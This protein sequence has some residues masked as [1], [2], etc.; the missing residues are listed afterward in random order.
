MKNFKVLHVIATL[1]E[2]LGGPVQVVHGLCSALARKGCDVTI[3]STNYDPETGKLD[4]P[5]GS[6]VN[7][8]GIKIHFF[9]IQHPYFY[10]YCPSL[11]HEL[12]KRTAEFDIVHIHGVWLYPIAIAA[13]Y[14]R[15][16][17]VPYLI[18]PLGCLKP[19]A[20]NVKK[21]KKTI[22]F[23]LIERRNLNSAAAIHFLNQEETRC[24][25]LLGLM[26]PG[27]IIPNGVEYV[28]ESRLNLLKNEFRSKFPQ[29]DKKKIILFLGRISPEKG[30]DRL[31]DAF[32]K[33]FKTR[34]DVYLV[35]VGPDDQG[36]GM[37][38]R[39]QFQEKSIMNH[40]IFT[41]YLSGNEKL[42]A[43][44]DA[45]V[46]CLP[47]Y[48][49]GHSIALTEAL[50]CGLP[51][52]ITAGVDFPD[53]VKFNAG[54]VVDGKPEEIAFALLKILDNPDLSQQMGQNGRKLILEKYTW[55]KIAK[56]TTKV[57]KQIISEKNYNG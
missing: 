53:L 43:L 33:L 40:V 49:E 4:V 5:L 30:L 14:C 18:R 6:L 52:V 28:D 32:G 27:L 1:S 9:Q 13:Y 21:L 38:L 15:K 11:G 37:K 56:Q 22:Y 7:N 29:L 12:M 50:M 39:Q 20:L 19:F 36:M 8:D 42:S 35:I 55:D 3:F 10:Y 16:Y 25:D 46:F 31:L 41:G 51:A 24:K 23:R 26:S 2:R 44:V 45:D 17:N 34:S 54:I 48:Q 47:S 57:Y